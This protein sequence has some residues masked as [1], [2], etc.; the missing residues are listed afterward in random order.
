MQKSKIDYQVPDYYDLAKNTQ[1][2]YIEDFLIE[3]ATLG[4]NMKSF[5]EQIIQA[6]FTNCLEFSGA[7]FIR[8]AFFIVF[9]RDSAVYYTNEFY[10]F[11]ETKIFNNLT[12]IRNKSS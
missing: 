5:K 11:R 10:I 12:I 7:L 9:H 4:L 6:S 8:I 1:I 2:L 3:L